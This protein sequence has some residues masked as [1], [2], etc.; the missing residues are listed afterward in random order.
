[1][2]QLLFA[3]PELRQ[4]VHPAVGN[5]MGRAGVEDLGVACLEPLGGLGRRVVREAQD[6]DV[7]GLETLSPSLRVLALRLVDLEQLEIVAGDQPVTDA[8]ARR[9]RMTVDE[10]PVRHG[11]QCRLATWES[12]RP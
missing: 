3:V 1:M 6:G 8:Q 12:T 9:A 11:R 5:P 7:G 2:T 10:D 4:A